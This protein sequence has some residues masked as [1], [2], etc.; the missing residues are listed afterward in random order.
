MNA[1]NSNEAV[2]ETEVF[3]RGMALVGFLCNGD[4]S[5]EAIPELAKD[6][7]RRMMEDSTDEGGL[8]AIKPKRTRK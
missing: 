1:I 8:A 2:T 6:L 3:Y 7:A 5:T 4:Y